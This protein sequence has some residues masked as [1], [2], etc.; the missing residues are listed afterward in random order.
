MLSRALSI[1]ILGFAI[2]AIPASATITYCNSGCSNSNS[3]MTYAAFEAVASAYTFPA[4]PITFLSGGLNGSGVYLDTSGTSFAGSLNGVGEPLSVS[5][6]ALT[7]TSS[8]SPS[9]G[10]HSI[11]IALPANTYAFA[12]YVTNASGGSSPNVDIVP[13]SVNSDYQLFTNASNG[14]QFFGIISA[15]PIANFYIGNL[16]GGGPIQINSFLMGTQGAGAGAETPEV[17]A[18][19]LTGTGLIALRQLSR[20]RKTLHA[21][22]AA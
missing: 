14:A 4:S 12:M 9:Q 6:T 15:T 5:G 2:A 7:Q 13:V 18:F 16:A 19:L 21:C 8:T 1:S 20:R 10:P 11:A 3:G 17:S 22:A